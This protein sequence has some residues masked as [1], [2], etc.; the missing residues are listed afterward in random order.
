MR[1]V[2][3]FWSAP[4]PVNRY[5]LERW[6]LGVCL[7]RQWYESTELHAPEADARKLLDAGIPFDEVHNIEEQEFEGI[8]PGY[9]ASSKLI[10][11]S[12]QEGPFVHLDE[13]VF[14]M[15]PLKLVDSPGV[16]V[17]C[18][19]T[20]PNWEHAYR[21][22][23]AALPPWL[24]ELVTNEDPYGYNTGVLGTEDEDEFLRQFAV[25]SLQLIRLAS[26][27]DKSVYPMICCEQAF[28]AKFARE[29]GV[30]V[31]PIFKDRLEMWAA[32]D[33][34]QHLTLSK[35]RSGVQLKV[36][37]MLRDRFPKEYSELLR[38]LN[39]AAV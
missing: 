39:V 27:Y 6:L 22:F 5:D 30:K 1:A 31:S 23:R 21:R 33:K 16:F 29:K 24:Q 32:R 3:S 13:D 25:K 35:F 9:W 7:A 14:L 19:D 18:P 20:G 15:Q 26:R 10:A 38:R 37:K 4:K 12:R 8:S 17:Q 11:V 34:Y 2:Y 36:R 28:F